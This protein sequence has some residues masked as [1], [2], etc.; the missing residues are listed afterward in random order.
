MTPSAELM[1]AEAVFTCEH[2]HLCI[3][4]ET[5]WLLWSAKVSEIPQTGKPLSEIINEARMRFVDHKH[6]REA[7]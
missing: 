3:R 5:G 1:I 2:G 7:Q 6:D 4:S